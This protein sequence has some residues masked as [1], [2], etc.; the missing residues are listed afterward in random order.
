MTPTPLPEELSIE[1]RGPIDAV[2]EVP[3]SKSITNRALPMAALAQG[4]S[5]LSGC[6]ESDDTRVMCEALRA[7]GAQIDCTGEPWQ[8]T[9]TSAKLSIPPEPLYVQNSGT[10]ARF[11]TAILSLAPAPIELDGNPRMRERPISQLRDA[12]LGLGARID[13]QGRG[14]CPPLRVRGGGLPGGTVHMDASASSQYVSAILIAAPYARE[15]VQIHFLGDRVVSRPYIDLTLQVMGDFGVEA[16]WGAETGKTGANSLRV[17][18]G[19]QYQAGSYAIEPDASSAVYPLCA[20]AI[21]GGRVKIKGI[22]KASLQADLAI[23]DLL[24][25]MGCS[26]TRTAEA[27]ELIGPSDGLRSL[28]TVNMNALPDAALAYAVVALFADGPTLITDVANLRIKETDRLDALQTELRRLG[29]RA[30]AGPDWLQIRPA[31][32]HGAS[33][34]TYD[35]HRIA[36]SFAV[37][38]LR[39][40]GVVIKDPGCVSKT[41]PN[42]F[43]VWGNV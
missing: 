37:A 41:W 42:F 12:M 8:V 35:D 3:G 36:M 33:I 20:A 11:L 16:S 9:G 21:S 28:E 18:A 1:T 7:L 26:V 29:A 32:L 34:E 31:P 13:I 5:Q 15:D 40:P 39:I 4:E 30:D 23:L 6:L 38:G 24:E 10:S 43:E 14:G 27:I 2:V 22:P 19:Q 25:R 17:A